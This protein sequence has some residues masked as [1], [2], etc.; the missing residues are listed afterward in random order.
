MGR[1]SIGGDDRLRILPGLEAK[2]SY[3]AKFSKRSHANGNAAGATSDLELCGR[4]GRSAAAI[5]TRATPGNTGRQGSGS[6][7]GGK[8]TV[9]VSRH[10]KTVTLI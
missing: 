1:C 6:L 10:G 2:A 7:L 8:P 3:L 4:P 5:Q 9:G